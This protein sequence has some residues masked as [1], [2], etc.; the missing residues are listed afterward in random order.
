M[1]IS[2][3]YIANC[4]TTNAYNLETVNFLAHQ[5]I[6][7]VYRQSFL[8]KIEINNISFN[9]SPHSLS[10]PTLHPLLFKLDVAK[11]YT[12]SISSVNY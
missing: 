6:F 9:Q 8:C 1:F 7:I 10:L 2:E 4:I 12:F 5:N 11:S 3:R